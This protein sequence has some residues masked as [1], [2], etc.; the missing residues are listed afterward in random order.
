MSA[1]P[2]KRNWNDVQIAIATAAI[3][4]SIGMWNL[5]ATPAKAVTTQATDPTV[6]PP[7]DPPTEPPVAAAPTALPHVKII[8][9]PGAAQQT[10][11]TSVLQQPQQPAPQAPQPKRSR[12]GGGGGSSAPVTH[13]R[14]S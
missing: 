6:P 10:I 4:T 13:T 5:F 8:F 7:T 1:K 9:T 2:T 14:S 12:G 3:V 11:T